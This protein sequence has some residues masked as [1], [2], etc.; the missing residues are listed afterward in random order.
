MGG[1]TGTGT[2]PEKDEKAWSGGATRLGLLL[3]KRK[4]FGLC[5]GGMGWGGRWGTPLEEKEKVGVND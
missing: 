5:L 4:Q 1:G 2:T 3:P